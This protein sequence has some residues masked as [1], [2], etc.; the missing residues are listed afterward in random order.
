EIALIGHTH[1]DVAWLW[2][3]AQTKEKAQRSFSTALRL[4]E[5]YPAYVFQS[6]QPQLYAYVKENDPAL[7]EKIKQRVKEGR[8][9]VEGAMWLESDTNLVSGESLVRQILF[10]KRFIKEEFGIDSKMLW[11]PDVFGY[12]AALPQILKKV[13]VDYFFTIKTTW[14]ETNAMPHDNMIWQGLDGSSVFAILGDSYVKELNPETVKNT[15]KTHKDKKYTNICLSTFGYGDG[16]GGPTPEMLERYDRLKHGLPGYP[17]L[18][19]QKSLETV[20]Q[21]ESQFLESTKKRGFTPKWVGE[22]Y[23]EMHRGTYTSMAKNKK[24]NRQSEFLYTTLEKA[25]VT[26]ML[27]NEKATYPKE[28]LRCNWETILK[29]QFHDIIPGSS[30]KEVY[31]DSDAEY[32]KLLSEGNAAYTKTLSGIAENVKTEGGIFVYNPTPFVYDGQVET[33]NGTV[34]VS[35]IPAGGYAVVEGKA[36]QNAV[37]V[38][39]KTIENEYL[40]IEFSDKYH[41]VSL[42]D[43]KQDR[44]LIE[45]GKEGNVLAV[46]EDYPRAYD[47]WEITEYY[48]QKRWVADN[49]SSVEII[50]EGTRGGVRIKRAYGNSEI[51]QTVLLREGSARL[52][53]ETE[54]EWHEDHVL[55]KAEFPFAIFAP[56]ATYEI[57]YGHIERPNH[58]NTSWDQAKFEVPAHKWADLSES[59]YGVSLLNDCKYGYSAEGNV[60]T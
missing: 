35:G 8:W 39:A 26:N 48:R 6:S 20:K 52:D 46:Y 23:L 7:Y 24:N 55:L 59:D 30:I 3:L 49:V 2:T 53:F 60:M 13:G 12:T 42:Y 43:K 45:A 17:K 9:E 31:E 37:C 32:E 50:N 51:L 33:E 18:R 1:I 10:G 41:L 4:M 40:R 54:I 58:R 11:L 47:A 57:Q 21:T 29:N 15:W 34:F 5:K 36:G 19:I 44:E 38:T 22:M 14:N 28:L 25:A 27:L 56:R 16:G